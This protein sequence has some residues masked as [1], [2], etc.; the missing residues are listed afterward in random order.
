MNPL[1]ALFRLNYNYATA[2]F[3]LLCY[4]WC[5]SLIFLSYLCLVLF[6]SLLY[7]YI[8]IDENWIAFHMR[9]GGGLQKT[10]ASCL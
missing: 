9:V 3:V 2:I 6:I 5:V 10:C 8:Y 1:D 7:I 4:S